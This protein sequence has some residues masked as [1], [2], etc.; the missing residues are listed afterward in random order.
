VGD[1][2]ARGRGFRAKQ[3]YATTRNNYFGCTLNTNGPYRADFNASR[4]LQA[5]LDES[6]HAPHAQ[7]KE[8]AA[9]R[10]NCATRTL[11]DFVGAQ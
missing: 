3:R 9:A 2:S 5:P 11:Y 7:E 10:L 1:L 8:A 6:E 4:A